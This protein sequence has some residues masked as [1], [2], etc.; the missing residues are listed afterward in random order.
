MQSY[1]F[2]A[3]GRERNSGTLLKTGQPKGLDGVV[4]G[5]DVGE[6]GPGKD[7]E[8]VVNVGR[9]PHTVQHAADT[10]S[11]GQY[12][13]GL[14]GEALGRQQARKRFLTPFS[15]QLKTLDPFPA[16]PAA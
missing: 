8:G 10:R 7:A 12:P 11:A 13:E 5:D 3:G 14:A 1:K 15:G 9:P 2:G 4:D 16:P 6:G